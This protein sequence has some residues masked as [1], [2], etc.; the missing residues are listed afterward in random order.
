MKLK[1]AYQGVNG[2]YS[3]LSCIN[4]FPDMEY[5]GFDCFDKAIQSVENGEADYAV[6]PVE[7][8]YAGRVS[9]VHFLLPD[10]KLHIIGEYFQ[11]IEHQLLAPRGVKIE[12]LK[13]VCSHPQAL[14]QCS[15]YLKSKNIVA[16]AKSDTAKA[17]QE[18]SEL[19][20]VNCGAIGSKLAAELYN[21]DV[22]ASNIEDSLNNTT[23]FLIMSRGKNLNFDDSSKI[24]TSI[25]FKTRNIPSALYKALG[26][27]ATNNLNIIKI[28][29]Y[30]KEGEFIT[31]QFYIEVEA[32]PNSKE[33]INAIEEL[34]YFSEEVKILG[35]YN[36][37]SF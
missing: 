31:A 32:N 21:L 30:M 27:F 20:C 34:E 10:T 16:V 35:S 3:H 28:E 15:K 14:A 1:I 13:N 33:F 4:L 29:S 22:L 7:N 26:G 36:K 24:N 11:R 25:L 23:R 37:A 18:V 9:D 5:V 6:I 19:N 17:C 2:A 12:D 8:S